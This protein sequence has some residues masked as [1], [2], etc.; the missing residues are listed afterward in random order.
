ML[1]SY[2]QGAVG[3]AAYQVMAKDTGISSLSCH[4]MFRESSG[5]SGFQAISSSTAS[6]RMWNLPTLSLFPHL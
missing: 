2:G 4:V 6:L 3:C 5:R 1:D